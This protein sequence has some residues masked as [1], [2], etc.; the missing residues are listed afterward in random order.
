MYAARLAFS[1]ALI[2]LSCASRIAATIFACSRI[3]TRCEISAATSR[4]RDGKH[5]RVVTFRGGRRTCRWA[6]GGLKPC[7]GYCFG[8][9]FACL[10]GCN[11]L[12]NMS[13]E[14]M[15]LR[16]V[17]ALKMVFK[18]GN[19]GNAYSIRLH[20]SGVIRFEVLNYS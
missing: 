13:E 16:Q 20:D 15:L 6:E 10:R 7:L 1:L 3:F 14:W 18:K 2:L 11:E 19:I 17:T 4:L 8:V 12:W 9:N 5:S